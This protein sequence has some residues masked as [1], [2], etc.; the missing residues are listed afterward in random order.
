LVFPFHELHTHGFSN[1][2]LKML[3]EKLDLFEIQRY[4]GVTILE[5]IEYNNYL[6]S[7]YTVLDISNL[8]V[9]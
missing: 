1:L 8:E 5:I 2:E 9:I 3:G 7:I 4:F 6:H